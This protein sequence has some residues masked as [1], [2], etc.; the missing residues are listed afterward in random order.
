MDVIVFA[1]VAFVLGGV[2]ILNRERIPEHLRRPLAISALIL[3][4]AA[5]AMVVANFLL[6]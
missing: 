3:V 5:F 1:I 4:V 6:L 2:I